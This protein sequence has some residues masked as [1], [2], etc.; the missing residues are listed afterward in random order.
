MMYLKVTNFTEEDIMNEDADGN[1]EKNS[2]TKGSFDEETGIL[3]ARRFSEQ[4]LANGKV[5]TEETEGIV[6]VSVHSCHQISGSLLPA[7]GQGI[8]HQALHLRSRVFRCFEEGEHQ[9]VAVAVGDQYPLAGDTR[10]VPHTDH[11]LC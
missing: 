8:I 3:K 4:K 6:A 10:A 2:L 9:I 7:I 11:L 5:I 1:Y